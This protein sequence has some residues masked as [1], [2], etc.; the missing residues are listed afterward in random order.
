[1]RPARPIFVKFFVKLCQAFR[2]VF[3]LFCQVFPNI[4]LAVLWDFKDLRGENLLFDEN[5]VS[6][7]FLAAAVARGRGDGREHVLQT[8]GARRGQR[9]AGRDLIEK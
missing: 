5:R 9:I 6:S 8:P 2:Q 7:S 1:M 4:S 3:G